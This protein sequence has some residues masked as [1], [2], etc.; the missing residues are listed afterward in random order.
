MQL[1]HEPVALMKRF[2]FTPDRIVDAAKEQVR[3]AREPS[4]EGSR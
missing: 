2:G 3:L 4:Q 1:H